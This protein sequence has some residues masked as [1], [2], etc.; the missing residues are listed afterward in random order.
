[1]VW[2]TADTHFGH[3]NILNYCYRPFYTIE[4][5]DKVLM[6]YLMQTVQSGD[7]LWHLGDFSLCSRERRIEL[8]KVI[9]SR[10]I[11]LRILRGN[12]DRSFGHIR[13]WLGTD[14]VIYGQA[15]TTLGPY[16]VMLHH[17]PQTYNG[18]T[19]HGH[20][21]DMYGKL[22]HCEQ[23]SA[24]SPFKCRIDV[25]VDSWNYAPVSEETLLA[26]IGAIRV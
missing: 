7:T 17:W 20:V 15:E 8:I 11:D 10:D 14:K 9:L 21:H 23:A 3:K 4:E 16:S 13:Q 25:G 5:H 1:M 12:H 6:H 19:L 2:F 26:H 22:H 18:I 24:S